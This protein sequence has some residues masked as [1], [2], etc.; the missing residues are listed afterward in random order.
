[1]TTTRVGL[2][3]SARSSHFVES[4]TAGHQ[5]RTRVVGCGLLRSR[6]RITRS[7]PTSTRW[8]QPAMR[9]RSRQRSSRCRCRY[10]CS[11]Y[12]PS[13]CPNSVLVSRCCRALIASGPLFA[14]HTALQANVASKLPDGKLPACT[15]RGASIRGGRPRAQGV[16]GRVIGTRCRIASGRSGPVAGA[17]IVKSCD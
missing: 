11:R 3:P 1:V 16:A 5:R 8:P 14:I 15:C 13:R 9:D 4:A 7:P 6:P 12:R 2:P 10:G 17:Q